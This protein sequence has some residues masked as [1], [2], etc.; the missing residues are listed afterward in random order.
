M[1]RGNSFETLCSIGAIFI[2]IVAPLLLSN[3]YW[4]SV[5]TM[6]LINSLMAASL[7]TI[8]TVGEFSLGHVGF[9]CLGAYTS[10]LL[11][12][13]TGLPFA[14]TLPAAGLISGLV[15]FVLGH[16][17]M[18]VKGIYFAILTLVTSESFRLLAYN[19]RNLTGGIDGLIGFPGAGVLS[20]PGLGKVDFG[21]FIEYYYLTLAIAC[22]SLFILY[23]LEK[24][25]LGFI[26]L[27]IRDADKLAGALGVN[28]LRYKVLAFSVA[29]FFSGIGGGL[30]AHF[31]RALSPHAAATFGIMT[32]IY[33]LTYM[34]VGGKDQFA[35]PIVGAIVLSLVYEFARPVEEYQPMI[36]GAIAILIVMLMPQGIVSIPG[37]IAGRFGPPAHRLLNSKVRSP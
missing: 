37:K 34:V 15:A 21:G 22:A 27:A 14:M 18:R 1:N 36:I 28:V 20:L 5:L 32:T 35:G 19:W 31:E 29:C 33:L 26:W 13:K 7:R 6:I 17:F 8:L 24:S 3:I 11:K 10:A 25:K 12:M 30:F 9:M 2:A 16:P 23:R 4:T